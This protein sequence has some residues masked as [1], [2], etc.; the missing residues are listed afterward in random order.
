MERTLLAKLL[1][2]ASQTPST[3]IITFSQG[4]LFSGFPFWGRRELWIILG[5]RIWR[6][7]HI[8]LW[9]FC[10]WNGCLHA[11]CIFGYLWILKE[12]TQSKS[13]VF[14]KIKPSREVEVGR[15]ATK[16]LAMNKITLFFHK[17]LNRWLF[18]TAVFAPCKNTVWWRDDGI[19]TWKVAVTLL[20]NQHWYDKFASLCVDSILVWYFFAGGGLVWAVCPVDHSLMSKMDT[21][22]E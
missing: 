17:P 18:E 5:R 14:R 20:V 10:L 6:G 12:I 7:V 11:K 8:Y 1:C 16:L 15:V 3:T 22:V 9:N 2:K 19:F 4:V 21:E 13:P